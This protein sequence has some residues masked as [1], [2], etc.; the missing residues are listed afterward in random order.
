MFSTIIPTVLDNEDS[1]WRTAPRAVVD[2]DGGIAKFGINSNSVSVKGNPVKTSA[3]EQAVRNLTAAEAIEIYE[4]RF[5]KPVWGK[6]S[7]QFAYEIFDWAVNS[8]GWYPCIT[9]QMLINAKNKKSV[10]GVDGIWG[11]E[12]NRAVDNGVLDNSYLPMFAYVREHFYRNIGFARTHL[13]RL[14]YIGSMS[15][16]MVAEFNG[17]V[18]IYAGSKAKNLMLPVLG[19]SS[20][21]QQQPSAS[22]TSDIEVQH[23]TDNRYPVGLIAL[24]IVGVVALVAALRR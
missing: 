13:K 15:P 3:N 18:Q 19:N 16:D 12:M 24:G 8:G 14:G 1:L 22:S 6:L 11:S 9:L 2:S 17:L 4:T 21:S 7:P 5:W 20:S 23:E 10:V